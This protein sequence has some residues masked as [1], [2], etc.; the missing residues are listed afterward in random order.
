MITTIWTDKT[1][2]FPAIDAT[3]G[4]INKW[5]RIHEI[6]PSRIWAVGECALLNG[7]LQL[8]NTQGYNLEVVIGIAVSTQPLVGTLEAPPF[9]HPLVGANVDFNEHYGERQVFFGWTS[10]AATRHYFGLYA[11]CKTNAIS[12]VQS[13][14]VN[15]NNGYLQVML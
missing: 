3:P 4:S 2:S 12:G 9:V 7:C 8:E 15:V 13:R 6:A 5:F 14:V 10:R 11:R 1:K